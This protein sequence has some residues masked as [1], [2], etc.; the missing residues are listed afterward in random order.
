MQVQYQK[1]LLPSIYDTCIR[2]YLLFFFEDFVCNIQ[3][4]CNYVMKIV[5]K[6]QN[7]LQYHGK[8]VQG[9]VN[10]ISFKGIFVN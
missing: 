2:I 7:L 4:E 10:Y 9:F 8:I 5:Y 1:R 6:E 3:N